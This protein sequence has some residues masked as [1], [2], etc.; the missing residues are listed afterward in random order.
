ML[1]EINKKIFSVDGLRIRQFDGIQ[2]EMIEIA[3]CRSQ[4]AVEKFFGTKKY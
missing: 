1:R 2:E 4:T 3:E